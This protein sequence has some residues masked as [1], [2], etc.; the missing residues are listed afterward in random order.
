MPRILNVF[1][2]FESF[3]H[4]IQKNEVVKDQLGSFMSRW[5]RL[6]NG[7]DFQSVLLLCHSF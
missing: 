7:P 6:S 2:W 1:V 4:K 5:T 3:I